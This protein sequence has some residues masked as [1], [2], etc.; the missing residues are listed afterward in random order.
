MARAVGWRVTV[1]DRRGRMATRA[2]FAEA[3][4][5]LGG[6]LEALEAVVT[7]TVSPIA[8]LMSHDFDVDRDAL[9]ALLR[10][11]A[12]YIGVLGPRRRTERMLEALG[13]GALSPEDQRRLHAPVGLAIGAETPQEIALAIVAEAQAA[14]AGAGGGPLRDR[15]TPIHARRKRWA[16]AVLAAGGSRRLGRPKQ[17]VPFRGRP[18]VRHVAEQACAAG[19]DEVA[20]VVGAHRD[21]IAAALDGLPVRVLEND[22]WSEGVASSIRL[23]AGWAAESG[24]DAVGIALADQP[25]ITA[26]HLARLAAAHHAGARRVGSAYSGIIGVP[27]VFDARDFRRLVTLEG[28]RGAAAILAGRG[29]RDGH[30]DGATVAVPWPDGALDV[31]TPRVERPEGTSPERPQRSNGGADGTQRS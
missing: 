1:F 7:S 31:D 15:S 6:S 13:A 16:C 12:A 10:T 22:G 25:G 27:A 30:D 20:V 9:G 28:D 29:D 5:V 18:L 23:A 24:M 26:G 17:L 2:R 19:C 14:L 3:D 21:A 11:R 4:H 8:V